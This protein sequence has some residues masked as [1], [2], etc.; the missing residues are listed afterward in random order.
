MIDPALLNAYPATN[1]Q[2]A[3]SGQGTPRFYMKRDP[4]AR[5]AGSIPVWNT[6]AHSKTQES[7]PNFQAALQY[8][9]EGSAQSNTDLVEDDSFGFG[10]L[11]DIVNPLHHIPLVN[12]LYQNI[13]GDTIKPSGQIIGGALF[14]GFAGAAAGIANVIIEEETGKSVAGNVVALVT[15]GEMP[16]ATRPHAAPEEM[17][18]TAAQL[19]FH[20]DVNSEN[21][22]A[23][24]HGLRAPV[25]PQPEASP[26]HTNSRYE[27]Y[28]FDE[29]RMA[30]TMVRRK[31]VTRDSPLPR[32]AL[33]APLSVNLALIETEHLKTPLTRVELSPLP[34]STSASSL[35]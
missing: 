29:E 22:P 3:G 6:P 23:I 31:S 34:S 11:V 30:G 35:P 5:M 9:E 7:A 33:A 24:A 14:G 13:S 2:T 26:S 20:D 1:T 19:A 27:R 28:I 32:Q 16:S 4:D 15:K 17:L 12:T 10:D 8:A 18:N 21:I 25:S